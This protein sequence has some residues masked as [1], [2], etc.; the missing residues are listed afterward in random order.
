MLL[1]PN[2]ALGLTVRFWGPKPFLME[3]GAAHWGAAGGFRDYRVVVV[4]ASPV[5]V[6]GRPHNGDAGTPGR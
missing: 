4:A 5:R 3:L 1:G 2:N 6:G